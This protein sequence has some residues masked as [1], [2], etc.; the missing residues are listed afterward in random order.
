MGGAKKGFPV[1]TRALAALPAT[2]IAG[3]DVIA[4]CRDDLA[5]TVHA[6]NRLTPTIVEVVLRAPAAARAFRPGQFYRLQNYEMHAVRVDDPA[7][8]RRCCR[9]KV[10]R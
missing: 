2:D 4:R 10:W 1:V 8:A 5:A 7:S 9:W 3:S 6:V